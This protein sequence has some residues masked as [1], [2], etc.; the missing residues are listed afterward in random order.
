M[1]QLTT[2]SPV[3]GNIIQPGAYSTIDTSALTANPLLN[4]RPVVAV[5]ATSLGGVPDT[6]MY[7]RSSG[8]ALSVLKGGI[9]YDMVRFAF[10]GGSPLVCFVRVGNSPTQSTI[11]LDATTGDGLTLTS[12]DYGSWT[13]NIYVTVAAD[14]VITI[15]YTDKLGFKYLEKYDFS[16]EEDFTLKDMAQAINGTPPPY[17]FQ[18][19]MFVTAEAGTGTLPLKTAPITAM[20]DGSDGLIPVALD[21]TA[22]LTALE[23]ELVDLIVPGTGDATV[24]AQCLQHC[25]NMSVPAARKERTTIVGGVANE[26]FTQAIARAGNLRD[27]RVQLAYPGIQEYDSSGFLTT[28]DP[29]Y[30]AAKLAG[31]HAALTDQAVSLC[32][33]IVPV[34]GV[35]TALSTTQGGPID[36]LL[37]AGVTPL[38]P[39]PTSGVWVVDSLSTYAID[40][41]F[42]D[43]HKIRSADAV[44]QYCR[45]FLES[46]F[47]G[48][49]NTAG[50]LGAIRETSDSILDDMVSSTLI[51]A[52]L[53]TQVVQSTD[54]NYGQNTFLV[55]LPV[56]LIDTTKFILL[57]I[58]L[59][60]ASALNAA[61]TS[62]TA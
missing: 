30:T 33:K 45:Y 41:N 36:Q 44:A 9:G 6:P 35:E 49:K 23:T 18:K 54:P 17:G 46:T 29:F 31:M 43:F 59:Q 57:T 7:F 39:A 56:M 34:A 24:H 22:G 4:R 28:Y 3:F 32:H 20:A 52:H 55:N 62:T 19:S 47:V 61:A 10:S 60:P 37:N 14:N 16:T 27:K 11:D 5:L 15:T 21:W 13:E 1:A 50:T 26:T 25:L 40:T 8:Q 2:A 53:P 12:Q 42:R 51:R 38:A 48:A 58:A